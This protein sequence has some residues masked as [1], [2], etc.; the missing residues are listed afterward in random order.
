MPYSFGALMPHSPLLIE[1][2][3][4]NN[5][6]TLSPTIKAYEKVKQKLIDEK[7]EVL[8]IISPHGPLLIDSFALAVALNFKFNL[9]QFGCFLSRKTFRSALKFSRDLLHF[10]YKNQAIKTVNY[11]MLDYASGIPLELLI[12]QES[13]IKVVPILCSDNLSLEEH[14]KLGQSIGQFL[15]NREERVAVIASGDLSHKISKSSPAGYSPRGQKFDNRIMDYLIRPSNVVENLLKLDD[16]Y[17]EEVKECSIKPLLV[18]LG[19]NGVDYKGEK[20]AYQNDFG[21]GYLTYLF[22]N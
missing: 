12:D 17:L 13:E 9:N 7:I 18:L 4:K 5:Y 6:P 21:V 3:S 8:I 16:K 20:L 15:E 14:F 2:I 19:I 22:N 10:V 1:E 11:Q